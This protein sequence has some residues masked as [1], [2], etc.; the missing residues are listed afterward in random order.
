VAASATYTTLCSPSHD[1]HD[2]SYHCHLTLGPWTYDSPSVPLE[3]LEGGFD[4]RPFLK[5]CPYVMKN[6]RAQIQHVKYD[7]CQE[8]FDR[9]EIHFDV[10]ENHEDD[11]EHDEDVED[12][13]DEDDDDDDEHI[14]VYRPT[15]IWPSC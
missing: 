15:C 13:D 4:L 9:L 10:E 14:T 3:L 12:D 5:E 6:T 7:C 11:A 1:R 8:K 2:H